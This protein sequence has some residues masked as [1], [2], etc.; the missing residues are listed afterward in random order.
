MGSR[1]LKTRKRPTVRKKIRKILKGAAPL[2]RLCCA[3]TRNPATPARI[4]TGAKIA[5]VTKLTPFLL[6]IDPRFLDTTRR[7]GTI[8]QAARPDDRLATPFLEDARRPR[9]A[10]DNPRSRSPELSRRIVL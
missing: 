9:F 7:A 3:G 5:R 8:R 10:Y 4:S 2:V 6:I 1:G